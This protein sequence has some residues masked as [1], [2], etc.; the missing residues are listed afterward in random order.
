MKPQWKLILLVITAMAIPICTYLLLPLVP[1]TELPVEMPVDGSQFPTSKLAFLQVIPSAPVGHPRICH[2][3]V[4]PATG[5]TGKPGTSGNG[6]I[7]CDA[8]RNTVSV[9]QYASGV[10][11]EQTILKDVIAPAHATLCDIDGD[12]DPDIAVAVLGNIEPDDDVIGKVILLINDSGSFQPHVILDD[13]RRVADVQPGD[14][15]GDGD[16]DFAVAVFG[17][18]RG[19]VLWLENRGELHF[20]R[21]ELLTAPGVIHVPAADFDGDG[22]LDI[23]AV[24]SQDEEEIW[25]FENSGTGQFT[26][27]RIWFTW[28]F[29]LGSAGLVKSDLD[30]DGDMDLLLPAGDNLEDFDPFPQPYHGCFWL[31]NKGDWNF[32][33]RRIATLGGTYAADVGD[34]DG[35]GDNDVALV[36]M[37][38]VWDAS[39]R[40]SLVWLENDGQQ[41]FTTWQIASAPTH[42]VT[43][44]IGD[45]SGD[46]INDI[47]AGGLHIRGPYDRIGRVTIWQNQGVPNATG[48]VV[49]TK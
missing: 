10:W 4:Q 35:D 29:D 45:I 19:Q 32:E 7:V 21:H 12:L 36:S 13:V 14:F 48:K 3:D 5:L 37:A 8:G 47:V 31:E 1:A 24:I 9:M 18:N 2:V 49:L 39:D 44:S 26:A 38:N 23:A 43:V 28:N 22:D 46:G 11:N 15:D 25:G 16:I 34:L 30:Q 40:A 17:Y 42:L 33:S 6:I 20:V 41:N 27:R